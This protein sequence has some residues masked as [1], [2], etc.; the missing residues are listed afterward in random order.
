MSSA[1]KLTILRNSTEHVLTMAMENLYGKNIIKA[2][3]PAIEDGFYFDFDSPKDFKLAEA[4]FP[5]I[6]KEMHRLISLDL[7]ISVE[8][9]SPDKA[10]AMFKDNPYKQELIKNILDKGDKKIRIVTIGKQGT[11]N[12]FPNICKDQHLKSTGEIKAFKLLSIAGAYWHGDEKNQMLTRVYGT[13]FGSKKDLDAYLE[14]R[15]LAE[16]NNHRQLGKKLE[17]FAIFP[18]IGSGLPVW[19]PKGYTIRRILEDYMLQLEKK[20]GYQH[21]LTPH[22]SRFSGLEFKLKLV[23]N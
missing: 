23:F 12:Y 20:T 14:N 3:G 4:D 16:E 19:L 22:I 11:D 13:A 6:E 10:K 1:D 18:E 17:L 8:L 7:P 9:V 21:I 2:M 15:Q 5:K